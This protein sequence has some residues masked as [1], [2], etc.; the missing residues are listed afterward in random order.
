MEAQLGS[1]VGN[2][3][4]QL[5]RDIALGIIKPGTKLNIEALKKEYKVSHPSVR[6]ALSLLA[7][8]KFVSSIDQKGFRVLK[9]SSEELK[10]I[11]RIRAELECLAFEW[12]VNNANID[13]RAG[14]VAAHH[15]LTEVEN[16]MLSDHVAFA[17]EWDERNRNFH[18]AIVGNCGSPQLLDLIAQ[19]YALTRRYRLMAYSNDHTAKG[20]K[21]FL[22]M[23]SQEH[24]NLKTAALAG[25]IE[26]GKDIIRSHIT[27]GAVIDVN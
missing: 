18:Y 6:E 21:A 25:D 17:L 26:V 27:K 1:V 9:T 12:S 2:L 22:K 13:W 24:E 23:S 8:E 4:N 3:A 20:L 15:A 10:D 11:T 16:E 5:R 14:I 7:G 19:N